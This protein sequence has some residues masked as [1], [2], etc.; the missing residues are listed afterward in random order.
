[1]LIKSGEVLFQVWLHICAL[2]QLL[3]ASIHPRYTHKNFL[4]CPSISLCVAPVPSIYC[5]M[6]LLSLAPFPNQLSCHSSLLCLFLQV[7][8][9]LQLSWRWRLLQNTDTCILFYTVL[10]LRRPESSSAQLW[11]VKLSHLCVFTFP[12]IS[13]V[14]SPFVLCDWIALLLI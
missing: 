2:S 6:S 12:C 10:Y 13:T 14:R 9:L 4:S 3:L 8:T 5:R 11:E 7:V 1:M